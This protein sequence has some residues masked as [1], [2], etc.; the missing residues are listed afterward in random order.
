MLTKNNPGGDHPA[1]W[2]AANT[3]LSP[4]Q[5][6]LTEHAAYEQM[7]LFASACA[8]SWSKWN[9]RCGAEH[10]VMQ[11]FPLTQGCNSFHFCILT[12]YSPNVYIRGSPQPLLLTLWQQPPGWL[13]LK[14]R[15]DRDNL[16][17]GG[18]GGCLVHNMEKKSV[19]VNR[20]HLVLWRTWWGQ[21]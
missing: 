4:L 1:E 15:A 11:V 21:G 8:F 2:G 17:N 5:D 13:W 20:E 6:P 18:E 19:L 12:L 10:L 7:A 3:V 16:K 14:Q 9:A